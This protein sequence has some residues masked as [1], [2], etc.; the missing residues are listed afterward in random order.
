MKRKVVIFDFD[1]TIADSGDT[2]FAIFNRLSSHFGYKK[3]SHDQ[4]TTLRNKTSRQMYNELKV[5]LL[6]LPFFARKARSELRNS[7][8]DIP[9]IV[10]IKQALMDLKN[11]NYTLGI[12]SSNTTENI[13]KFLKEHQLEVF[14][15]VHTS[16]LFAKHRQLGN[17]MKQRNLKPENITYIGDETRDVEAGQRAGVRVIAVSWG[18][19]STS[20][21]E[22]EKPA[23]LVHTPHELVQ[24]ITDHYG[25]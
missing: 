14:D 12:L 22:A 1:G 20:I 25:E 18:I 7:L 23:G 3:L 16:S 6:K 10:G 5:P 4:L 9:L 8:P 11:D 13:N 24:A 15:F 21:L 17:I 2:L 19:N